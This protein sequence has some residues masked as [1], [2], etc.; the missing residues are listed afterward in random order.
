MKMSLEKC[1]FDLE[2][3][4]KKIR[5]ELS[6][7]RYDHT[8]GVEYTAAALAMVHGE[9]TFRAMTAGLLHD[10][11]KNLSVEELMDICDKYNIRLNHSEKN[12]PALIHAK[13]GA[14][15]ARKKYH[16]KDE[17]ILSAIRWHT[18]GKPD[19]TLLEKIIFVSDYIEPRRDKALCLDRIRKLAFRDIDAA[20]AVILNN[21]IEY[22]RKKGEYVD[23]T[24][25][26]AL[27][28]YMDSLV[29]L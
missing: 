15:L 13:V 23:E 17:E 21:T 27:D 9:D 7:S 6:R 12:N 8:I 28:F 4:E 20:V 11:A 19:M 29:R 16:I 5:K 25:V 3:I 10:C 22:V 14:I 1:E 24:A 18:T 26:M 2:K